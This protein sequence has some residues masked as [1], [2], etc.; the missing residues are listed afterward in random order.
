MI[1]R[2]YINAISK[3]GFLDKNV[4]ANNSG[5]TAVKDYKGQLIISNE[6]ISASSTLDIN[7]RHIYNI[8]EYLLYPLNPR[9]YSWEIGDN[10]G[11]T[12]NLGSYIYLGSG[13]TAPTYDD[14][15]LESPIPLTKLKIKSMSKIRYYD[16][17]SL[18]SINTIVENVSG[19]SVDISEIGLYFASFVSVNGGI[20]DYFL[21]ARET[22]DTIT[23]KPGEVRSFVMTIK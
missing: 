20:T 13:T 18:C 23:M 14:Y 4:S 22:F 3:G 21:L 11:N 9:T 12:T 17:K 8:S 15:T 19:E 6:T 16:F 2:N 1:T 5:K 7:I 10:I